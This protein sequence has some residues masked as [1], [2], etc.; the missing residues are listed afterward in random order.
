MS[1]LLD[2]LGAVVPFVVDP[3]I[4]AGY[5]TDITG[6]FSGTA[7]AVV[8]PRTAGE[9][10]EI[11]AACVR[12]GV[13]L[14]AQ[15]GNTGLVGGGVPRDGELVVSLGAL[16][17]VGE[18]D[19]DA[20][21]V[22]A[23]AGATLEVV[24]AHAAAV[25][26]ELPIDFPARS[27]ATIGGMVATN[28]GGAL[29]LRHGSMRARVVGLEAVLADAGL[30]RRM[31]G[32]VKDNAGY[33]LTQLLVGSEGTLGIVTA[34]RL[35]LE[36][37]LPFRLAALFGVRDLERGLALLRA[38][39]AVPGL[40][41]VD[42]FDAAG[43]ELVRAHKRLR[44]PLGADHAWYVIAQCAARDD[45]TEALAAAVDALP[46]AP[47]VV[48][49]TDTTGRAEL[50]EYREALNES[51]RATGVPHKLDVGLPISALPTVDR[52]LRT[53]L[54][55]HHPD[56]QVYV[57]GHLGDGNLHVNVVGPA[58]DDERVDDVVLRLVGKLGGTISAE[59]GIGRAKR[60]WLHL[61]RSEADIAAMRAIKDALDPAGVMA[62]GRVLPD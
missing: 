13:P 31:T 60:A 3:D 6:R 1:A 9:V 62:P 15:G 52:D 33:D 20:C 22:E 5:E 18:V 56:W 59:H 4:R 12:S 42:V 39:R 34:A 14:V 10:S 35:R 32:L 28:A 58:P 55:G 7:L 26:L 11:V 45:M 37:A 30:V 48:A 46:G 53:L 41:A 43:M 21:Q 29:A 8:R 17:H 27:S 24:R 47:E 50:W 54:A 2:D 44:A 40:E 38:L 57:Y 49:A 61:C 16:D 25:G 19:V 51:I 36:P 23:G